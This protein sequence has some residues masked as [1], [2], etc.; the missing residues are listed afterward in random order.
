MK[1][2]IIFLLLVLPSLMTAEAV[3]PRKIPWIDGTP[4]ID[5]KLDDAVWQRVQSFT[6]F[7]NHFPVDEGLSTNQT[8]VK[9]YHDGKMLYI[10]AVYHDV[11]S[12]NNIATLKRDN[13]HD[14]VLLSDCFGVVLDPYN[15]GDS[16]Y[17][18][19]V[20]AGGV[21]FDALIGD[22]Q[23]LN[24]SWSAIWSSKMRQI[25]N[26]KV[27][28]IAIPL[29]AI[30]FEAGEQEWGIQF[31]IND[32]KINL[33]TTL[34]ASPR[35]FT[36]YDLR[37]TQSVTIDK[38]PARSTNKFSALPAISTNYTSVKADGS[39]YSKW[40]PSL[41]GQYNITSSL[42]L[43]VTLNPDFSQVEVDQQVTNLSRFAINFPEKRKFFLENSDLFSNLGSWSANPFY[44]RTI[45]SQSNILFGA[46]LSGNIGANTRIGILNAQTKGFSDIN[47]NNFTTLVGR[48]TFSSNFTGTA[49]LVNTQQPSYHNRI[50]GSN[51]NY[52]SPDNRWVT[53]AKYSKAL[54]SYLDGK[55]DLFYGSVSYNTP[56]FI[57]VMDYENVGANYIA[58]SGFVPYQNNYDAAS[59]QTIKETY[60][61]VD[62][63]FQIKHFPKE[64]KSVD[65]IRRIWIRNTSV[66]NHDNSLRTST[67][68]WSPFAIRFKN[69]SYVYLASA[70]TIDHLSYS[71]DFLQN[72][73]LIEPGKYTQTFVRAGYWS[74][75]T[76]PFFYQLKL[77]YGQFYGGTR[78]NPRVDLSYR[79]LPTAVISASYQV[80]DVR[81]DDLG[82]RTFHLAKLTTEIY[83]NNQL[84]W[85]TYL[86]YNTQQDNFNINSR[87]Q[88]EYKPLSYVYVVLSNNYN[89][90]FL[91]KNWGISLKV[92]RRFDF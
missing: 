50:I 75:N 48:H 91:S 79:L 77:E 80:N 13:Y 3:P 9:L 14:G 67:W 66:F 18:F 20:N 47:G 10:G 41:D 2:Q 73:N 23:R 25:G 29:D 58:E 84:N 85:T 5:G 39:S 69:R 24:E 61:K 30:N 54:T 6:G 1:S 56:Q 17:L 71:F 51:L 12:T 38:L 35:N 57:A 63:G 31:F 52:R 8:E 78:L 49:Y 53:S 37:F 76:K 88:W 72:G 64:S 33:F 90:D 89:N 21:Q 86:Q 45:G 28:E 7:Y 82:K 87:I 19:A 26:D 62:A 22:I 60:S 43:D 59:Q 83:I 65:W 15:N 81:I 4:S 55:N 46:K 44:S 32:A 40:T 11:E 68:F 27:Y 92:N 74:P 16:G 42:R 34:V 36:Q 70:T